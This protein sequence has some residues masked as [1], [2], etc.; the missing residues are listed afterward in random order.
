M[1]LAMEL[2]VWRE[3]RPDPIN[4]GLQQLDLYLAGLGLETG[5]LVIFDQRLGLPPISDRTFTEPATTPEHCLFCLATR[6]L[7]RHCNNLSPWIIVQHNLL[8]CFSLLCHP[9]G[10]PL[11]HPNPVAIPPTRHHKG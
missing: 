6:G 3:G 5:W 11:T 7:R 2:K 1:S 10:T 9:M 8:E 4:A